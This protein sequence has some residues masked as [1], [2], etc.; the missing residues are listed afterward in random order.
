VLSDS[1]ILVIY[2]GLCDESNHVF[3][4]PEQIGNTR[5]PRKGRNAFGSI[6]YSTILLELVHIV[7][8][9]LALQ[10]YAYYISHCPVD[11]AQHKTVW[12]FP[13]VFY[14]NPITTTDWGNDM[15]ALQDFV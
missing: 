10:L 11:E 15:P 4:G 9:I 14:N 12:L 1:V 5:L 6:D 13:R 7:Q 2:F 8:T 3:I